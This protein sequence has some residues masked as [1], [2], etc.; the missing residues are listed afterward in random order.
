MVFQTAGAALEAVSRAL[1]S[2]TVDTETMAGRVADH[3]DAETVV[4]T[5]GVLV[6]RA[7]TRWEEVRG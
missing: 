5:T 1:T 6:D 2:L 3:V 7:R 4:E